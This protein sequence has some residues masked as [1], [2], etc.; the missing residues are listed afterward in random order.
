MFLLKF[1]FTQRWINSD[2]LILIV[3]W[4]TIGTPVHYCF[5]YVSELARF[6]ILIML[7][8]ILTHSI[9]LIGIPGHF[10]VENT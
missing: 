6:K 1:F 10:L 7:Y 9:D 8:E 2:Y 5:L 3:E 4:D